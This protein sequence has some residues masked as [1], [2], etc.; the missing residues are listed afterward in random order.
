VPAGRRPAVGYN[1]D[2]KGARMLQDPHKTSVETARSEDRAQDR[3]HGRRPTRSVWWLALATILS[4]AV[5]WIWVIPTVWPQARANTAAGGDSRLAR[6][7][8]GDVDGAFA[9]MDGNPDFFA[10]FKPGNRKCGEPLA[11]VDVSR[12]PGFAT[13]P[14]RIRS[15][16][17]VSPLFELTDAPR[18]VAIPYPAPYQAG[19][20][21]LSVLAAGSQPIVSLF[22]SWSPR[23]SGQASVQVWWYTDDDGKCARSNG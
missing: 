9:T 12:P 2:I 10:K 15:G 4:A 22:P 18:R 19:R 20:G 8:P 23:V 1:A 7:S 5:C 17:Y 21:V 3:S 14:I 11:W 13:G 16:N 6:V